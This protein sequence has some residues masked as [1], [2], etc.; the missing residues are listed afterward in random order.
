[1]GYVRR[2]P[3]DL[4]R[5]IDADRSRLGQLYSIKYSYDAQF[6][7]DWE[8]HLESAER[9]GQ[10]ADYP[11][12]TSS[13]YTEWYLRVNYPFSENPEHAMGGHDE[14][15]NSLRNHWALD[16]ALRF[17]CTPNANLTVDDAFQMAD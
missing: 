16:V 15:E 5:P 4:Y 7:E 11:Y 13:D 9:R 17:R 14:D 6:W 1:M 12:L 10:K 2:I 3:R 8:G